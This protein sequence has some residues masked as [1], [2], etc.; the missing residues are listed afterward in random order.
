MAKFRGRLINF[1]TGVQGVAAGGQAIINLPVNNR[2]H[3]VDLRCSMV[4]YTGNTAVVP[5]ALT[6]VGGGANT[7]TNTTGT[8]TPVCVNGQFS[9]GVNG[10]IPAGWWAAGNSANFAV[11]DRLTV[12][13]PTGQGVILR[14]TVAGTGALGNATFVIDSLGTPTPVNPATLI[15][16]MKLSVN[17]QN[18]RDISPALTMGIQ[19][20]CGY[21]P[22]FGTLSILFTE[23]ELNMLRDNALLSWDLTGQTQFSI[24]LTIAAGVA[25]PSVNGVVHFDYNRNARKASASDVAAGL[26]KTVGTQIPFLQPV[27]M[28]AFTQA[29][30]AGRNDIVTL[31]WSFPI[32]RLWFLGTVPGNLYQLEILADGTK[33]I[34]AFAQDLNE[35]YAKYGYQIG[36]SFYA[37]VLGGGYGAS[38]TLGNGNPA[39]Q[40]VGGNLAAMTVPNGQLLTVANRG[41]QGFQGNNGPFP[42]DMAAIFDLDK[43]PWEALTVQQSL[44]IRVYSVVAQT[45]TIVQ[46][47]LP[48][49]FQS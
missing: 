2:C 46:E 45:L 35:A 21:N 16:G 25:S 7:G 19:A 43:R 31:P 11:G 49:G 17:G 15:T 13:D 4:N 24:Q 23:P 18:M 14:C 42:F 38:A 22:G 29:I 12:P 30:V 47:T 1:L 28:H 40:P 39:T 37:P 41:N 26:A 27:A 6:A 8:I 44:I 34:E 32:R 33:I 20:A 9:P 10:A 3:G 5:V 36:N 48:G